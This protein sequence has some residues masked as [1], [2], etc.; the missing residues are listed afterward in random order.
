MHLLRSLFFLVATYDLKLWSVHVPGVLNG[1]AD[2]L[3]RNDNISFLS[4]VPSA[5]R[6]P[7]SIPLELL[8]VLVIRRADWT[9]VNWT[10]LLKST[11]PKD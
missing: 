7:D 2:A 8:D 10:E 9:S 11:L 4:Q 1:A 5:L 6:Q 3:S